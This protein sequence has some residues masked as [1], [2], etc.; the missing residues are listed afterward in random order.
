MSQ[1]HYI[2][3][4]QNSPWK[5]IYTKQILGNNDFFF[6]E[7]FYDNLGI[8]LDEDCCFNFEIK[9][10][11]DFVLEWHDYFERYLEKK[12]LPDLSKHTVEHFM[13]KN[14]DQRKVVLYAHYSGTESYEMQLYNI[15]RDMYTYLD[16]DSNVLNDYTI[17]ITLL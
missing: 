15:A 3:V 1:R 14:S 13:N 5:E 9:N 10:F 6:D 16:F 11:A 8:K 4:Y 7:D 2:Q 17:T 12:G